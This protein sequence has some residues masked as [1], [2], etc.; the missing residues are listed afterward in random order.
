M[1][2]TAPG[3]PTPVVSVAFALR[4]NTHRPAPAREVM[5]ICAQSKGGR[6]EGY[7]AESGGR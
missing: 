5:H 2:G 3:A 7:A 6:G 1:S 4:T